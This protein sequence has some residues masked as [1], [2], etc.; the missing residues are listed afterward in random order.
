MR[1]LKITY[2]ISKATDG[3]QAPSVLLFSGEKTMINYD[4][5]NGMIVS[6]ET[7]GKMTH[8]PDTIS[9]RSTGQTAFLDAYRIEH[10]NGN[11]YKVYTRGGF[12][13]GKK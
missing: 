3:G 1:A 9:I 6:R 12:T 4:K 5:L 13:Y 2:T 10:K 8:D 11:C 7:L